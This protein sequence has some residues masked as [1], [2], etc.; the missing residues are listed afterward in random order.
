MRRVQHQALQEDATPV[1]AATQSQIDASRGDGNPLTG[2]V[3]AVA[4]ANLVSGGQCTDA[5]LAAAGSAWNGMMVLCQRGS[6]SFAEKTENATT[7]GADGVIIYNNA[8][9]NFNG[10]LG[11]GVTSTIP[12][13]SV[14]QETGALLVAAVGVT[15]DLSTVFQD[16]VDGY[17]PYSGTSMATP[18]VAGVAAIAWSAK[19]DATPAEVRAAMTST[20]IDLGDP[21]RDVNFGY[22]LVQALEATA[23]LLDVNAPEGLTVKWRASLRGGKQFNLAWSEGEASIDVWRNGTK[24]ATMANTGAFSDM[25]GIVR[26]HGSLTYQVCNAGSTEECTAEVNVGY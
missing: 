19:P 10:T 21:G 22:G 15:A 13:V 9:G 1:D 12:A 7:G 18:H 6:I 23:V 4:S 11:A 3:Q 8:P 24:V 26:G 25:P 5:E 2:S 20:A 17:G 16:Q 14:S